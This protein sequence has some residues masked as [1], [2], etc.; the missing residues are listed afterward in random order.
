MRPI[1]AMLS[2]DGHIFLPV[3]L[4][5]GQKVHFLQGND[6]AYKACLQHEKDAGCNI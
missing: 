4:S 5:E 6:E 3:A 2:A 1:T